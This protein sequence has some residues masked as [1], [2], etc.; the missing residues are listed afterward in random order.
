LRVL[1]VRRSFVVV[2][3]VVVGVGVDE[4]GRALSSEDEQWGRGSSPQIPGS[5]FECKQ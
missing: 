1:V 4:P 3:V 2:V 5:R